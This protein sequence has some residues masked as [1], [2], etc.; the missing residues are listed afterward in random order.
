MTRLRLLPAAALIVLSLTLS[1]PAQTPAS[2]GAI[3]THADW[4]KAASADVHSIESTINAVYNVISGP[5]GQARNWTR[6]RSL[7]VP[8]ARLVPIRETGTHADVTFLD[9]DAYITR[10]NT[11]MEADGFFEKSIANR[12]EVYG[13]LVHV[14]ST[15][16]SRHAASDP[17]PFA[18]GINSF[19]LLKDGDRYWVVQILWDAETP[20]TPIPAKYLSIRKP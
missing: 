12:V 5:K 18:R 15:Y 20:T 10:A 9:I 1:A 7:F 6:M 13:N 16:E 2:A 11:R 19:Q 17:K 3:A 8:G 4:P 14:W